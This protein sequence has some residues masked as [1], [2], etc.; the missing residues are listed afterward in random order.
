MI[1]PRIDP[2]CPAGKEFAGFA[3]A[4]RIQGRENALRSMILRYAYLAGLQLRLKRFRFNARRARE[5]QH[6]SAVGEDPPPHARATTAVITASRTIR[7]ADDFRRSHPVA[8][9]DDHHP[10]IER[11]LHGDETALFAPGTRVLMFAMSS[12]TTGQPKRLP[13]TAELF[14]EYKAG[15]RMWA[16]VFRRSPR[17]AVQADGATHQRLATVSRTERRALRA[18]QRPG[19]DDTSAGSRSGSSRSRRSCRKFT[20]RPRDTILRSALRWPPTA[21]A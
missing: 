6:H 15:W 17:L 4:G 1:H 14:R 10:Y 5:V 21:S 18:N 2:Q 20:I 19:G 7:T 8:S 16:R 9:Y 12:G 13:I 3:D 11:V